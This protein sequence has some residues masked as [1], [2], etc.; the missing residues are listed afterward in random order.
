MENLATRLQQ[1][2]NQ[3]AQYLDPDTLH[4]LNQGGLFLITPQEV[5]QLQIMDS[6]LQE[7]W[8]TP[9]KI[10]ILV[11]LLVEYREQILALGVCHQTPKAGYTELRRLAE[12]HNILFAHL[13]DLPLPTAGTILD[14]EAARR[15]R[16]EGGTCS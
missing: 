13:T 2:Q 4:L 9:E 12:I 16:Q 5:A 6:L 15:K 7:S 1:A 3:A 10:F 8:L 14:L 11:G